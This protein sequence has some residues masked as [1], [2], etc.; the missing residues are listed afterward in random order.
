MGSGR[1]GR[2]EQELYPDGLIMEGVDY[3]GREK[4][5]SFKERI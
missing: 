5:G 1:I 3:G 4:T 2:E